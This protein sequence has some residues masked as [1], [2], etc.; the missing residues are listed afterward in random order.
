MA[1]NHAPHNPD[2]T[3][4]EDGTSK[5]GSCNPCIRPIKSQIPKQAHTQEKRNEPTYLLF[6]IVGCVWNFEYCCAAGFNIL[7]N[8][9]LFSGRHWLS[10]D[11]AFSPCGP[12]P[13]SLASCNYRT[14]WGS[15]AAKDRQ[16]FRKTG[17]CSTLIPCSRRQASR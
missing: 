3:C 15:S 5:F 11:L 8:S 4:A 7:A 16:G 10:F 17:P 13:D 1:L 2:T 12:N 9:T 6:S 14:T